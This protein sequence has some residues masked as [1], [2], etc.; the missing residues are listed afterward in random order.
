[1]HLSIIIPCHNEQERIEETIREIL[2]Y[3]RP[4]DYS[5]EIV[6]VNNHSADDT[7]TVLKKLQR[8]FLNI[9]I[10]SEERLGKGYAVNRGM[11]EAKGEWRLFMDADSSTNICHL[12]SLLE[13]AES[14]SDVVIGS[15][16]VP[17]ALIITP[18]PFL[19]RVLGKI[20]VW[21]VQMIIPLHIRDTQNGFKLFNYRAAE[22]I[23]GVQTIFG[24]AFDVEILKLAKA[25]GYKVEEVPVRWV[26]DKRS[27]MAL[28]GMVCMLF[29]VLK[30]K[31]RF[32][33]LRPLPLITSNTNPLR[34]NR[35]VPFGMELISLN[36]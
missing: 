35:I 12:D 18:Q 16:K 22:K 33:L 31:W 8:E 32:I 3:L 24:W 9:Q 27:K 10:V 36:I 13:M 30:I 14:G 29:E 4:K 2:L 17:G 21:L 25:F 23:F 26:D 11:L 15:R 19:R 20:F 7:L 6:A 1:M 34:S 5:W 28:G